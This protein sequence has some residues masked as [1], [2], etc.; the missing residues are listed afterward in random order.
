MEVQVEGFEE[1]AVPLMDKVYTSAL[2]LAR[3]PDEAKDLVQETYL[4]AFRFWDRFTPGTNCKAWLLTILYNVFRN[5]YRERQRLPRT[6]DLDDFETQGRAFEIGDHDSDPARL[7]F[8]AVLDAEVEEA[9]R[10]LPS[11]FLDVIVMVDVQE[12]T[13]EET[14]D[15][16]GCPVGTIRSRLSRG[17]ALLHGHLLAYAEERGLTKRGR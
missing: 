12:L 15:A 1:V 6:V 4:R 11:D 10:K 5:R 2:Y 16:V 7:V 13:Y 14:A 9:L 3:D 17:R 8:S